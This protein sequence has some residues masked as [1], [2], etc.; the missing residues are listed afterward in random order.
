LCPM[1]LDGLAAVAGTHQL[2]LIFLGDI[3]RMALGEIAVRALG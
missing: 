3:A 2:P 1:C